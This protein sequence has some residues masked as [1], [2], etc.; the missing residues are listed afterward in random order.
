MPTPSYNDFLINTIRRNP[1][2][3]ARDLFKFYYNTVQTQSSK[4][5]EILKI[6][7]NIIEDQLRNYN[8]PTD[9]PTQQA[10]NQEV[11]KVLLKI[12]NDIRQT[13]ARPGQELLDAL[14]IILSYSPPPPP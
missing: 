10:I 14:R 2:F 5:Y 12:Q 7:L 8:Y 6:A 13:N 1:N 11:Q 9:D 3:N 4:N